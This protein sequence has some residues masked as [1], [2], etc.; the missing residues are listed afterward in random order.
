[1]SWL[2]QSWYRPYSLSLLLLPITGLFCSIVC[3]RRL[4]YQQGW[5]S[6]FVCNIPVIIVG[7]ISVGGT[8]KT[9]VVIAIAQ[10]LQSMGLKPAIISRG[11]GGKQPLQPIAVSS[12]SI[13]SEVGDEALLLARRANCPVWIGRKRAL[14]AQAVAQTTDCN[15]IV[16]DDG[17]QHYA[18][19][20]DIELAVIDA[21]RGHGNGFCLPAGPLREPISRLK[22]VDFVILNGT[23]A[24]LS[25]LTAD[26]Q[27][28]YQMAKVLNVKA[29]L[30]MKRN[31]NDWQGKTVHAV[32]GIG[33]PQRFFQLFAPYKIDIIHHS[34]PDHH[35]Y[36]EKELDFG[37]EHDIIMTEKDAVKCQ[38]FAKS[39]MY[40]LPITVQFDQNWQHKLA[41]LVQSKWEQKMNKK[42][43]DILVCPICQGKLEYDKK[44]QELICKAD[45]LAFPIQ[46]DAPVML[47]SE[48]RHLSEAEL[49]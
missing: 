8:G 10:Y 28:N 37:D 26:T 34:F 36:S 27:I 44:N 39:N 3:L 16:T 4:A 23:G 29:G 48:A 24:G 5:L 33:H 14:V 30:N 43:L 13:A 11:Y 2:E 32:A 46:E 49:V 17:L 18:L 19:A 15:I 47:E 35:L 25:N 7:N 38:L 42:L 20:R 12:D 1:M 31:L 21:K 9:P 45:K 22:Q 6:S 41:T 40:Y